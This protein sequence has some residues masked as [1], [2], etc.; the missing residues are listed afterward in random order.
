MVRCAVL[1][2]GVRLTGIAVFRVF[3]G[4]ISKI[5]CFHWRWRYGCA[6]GTIPGV[7]WNRPPGVSIKINQLSLG[8]RD[9][10]ST[11]WSW[12]PNSMCNAVWH[13]TACACTCSR[14]LVHGSQAPLWTTVWLGQLLMS[15]S[16]KWMWDVPGGKHIQF[17][18][19]PVNGLAG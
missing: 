14:Q 10:Y 12:R 6:G 9:M 18:T 3:I 4:L 5:C 16:P 2:S 15:C 11:A 17:W 19:K 7:R 1:L 13:N 8:L